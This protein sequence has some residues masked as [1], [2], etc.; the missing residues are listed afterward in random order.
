MQQINFVQR[1]LQTPVQVSVF[2]AGGLKLTKPGK[3]H[4]GSVDL[5]FK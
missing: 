3:G 5:A 4:S 2:I 1:I